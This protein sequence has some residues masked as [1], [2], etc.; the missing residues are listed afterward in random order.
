M[1]CLILTTN[2]IAFG[3]RQGGGMEPDSR[4]TGTPAVPEIALCI[5]QRQIAG[6][7]PAIADHPGG[8]HRPTLPEAKQQRRIVLAV[9][10]PIHRQL[11]DFARSE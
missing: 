11:A 4:I 2:S 1:P 3:E 6:Q 10:L 9:A 5:D 7:D 8:G